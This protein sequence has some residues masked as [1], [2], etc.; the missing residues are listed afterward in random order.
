MYSR[1]LKTFHDVYLGLYLVCSVTSLCA[2]FIWTSG[3]V[4]SIVS[5]TH[6]VIFSKQEVSGRRVACGSPGMNVCDTLGRKHN[7]KLNFF[8][9]Y[10]VRN[11]KEIHLSFKMSEK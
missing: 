6:T 10:L 4:T 5:I 11:N 7:C 8:S 3:N 9:M 2:L 1:R